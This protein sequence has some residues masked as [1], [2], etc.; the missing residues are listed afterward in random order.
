MSI[1]PDIAAFF[2]HGWNVSKP[3]E[4]FLSIPV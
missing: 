3:V 4:V 2:G 1:A